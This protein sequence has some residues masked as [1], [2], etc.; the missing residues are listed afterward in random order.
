L[1]CQDVYS[2]R[3]AKPLPDTTDTKSGATST[4]S[5][6]SASQQQQHNESEL[7][8]ALLAWGPA[9]DAR[10]K[11]LVTVAEAEDAFLQEAAASSGMSSPRGPGVPSSSSSKGSGKS[12][13]GNKKIRRRRPLL[14]FFP[15]HNQPGPLGAYRGMALA[16]RWSRRP[17]R[18]EILSLAGAHL[19]PIPP[20]TRAAVAQR[21]LLTVIFPLLRAYLDV[22]EGKLQKVHTTDAAQE[23]L[24]VMADPELV[25]TLVQSVIEFITFCLQ[26]I[27]S[28]SNTSTFTSF[29]SSKQHLIPLKPSSSPATTGGTGTGGGDA[30]SSVGVGMTIDCE[31]ENYPTT[32]PPANDPKLTHLMKEFQSLSNAGQG[33]SDIS[34]KWHMGLLWALQLRTQCSLRGVKI[35]ELFGSKLLKTMCLSDSLGPLWPH[36]EHPFSRG[37]GSRNRDQALSFVSDDDF[38]TESEG[39][40]GGGGGSYY[41]LTGASGAVSTR[42]PSITSSLSDELHSISALSQLSHHTTQ[43]Q[44][45][46]SQHHPH[47]SLKSIREEFLL[48]CFRRLATQSSNI[49]YSVAEIWGIDNTQARLV[50]LT[51]LLELGHDDIIA[52]LINHVT[53]PP[54]PLTSSPPFP[55]MCPTV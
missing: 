13:S 24:I 26:G 34:S 7:G 19:L 18:V 23:F 47:L 44:Q 20:I 14:L 38:Q 45:Q 32:W 22:E 6:S 49:V 41:L 8:G 15:A 40:A 50:H 35:S 21:I 36:L 33:I 53:P 27:A 39:G 42:S 12:R 4:S 48:Q 31:D 10:W 2:R 17:K 25:E 52:E 28:S 51:T 37:D 54:S 29:A 16:E 11:E 46:Q 55:L 9:A 43:Q 5:S 30:A 1:R 3:A